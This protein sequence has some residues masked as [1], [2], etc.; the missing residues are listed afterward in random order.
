MIKTGERE[1]EREPNLFGTLGHHRGI[2]TYSSVCKVQKTLNR[3]L[4]KEN[5]KNMTKFN[6]ENELPGMVCL[7]FLSMFAFL[8]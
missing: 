5:L 2:V 8:N 6:H 7:N 1:R 3:F 4:L